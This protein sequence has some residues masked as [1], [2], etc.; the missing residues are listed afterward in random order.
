MPA[1]SFLALSRQIEIERELTKGCGNG[2]ALGPAKP[3]VS[4]HPTAI[5]IAGLAPVIQ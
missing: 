5:V 1:P 4:P 2:E 3:D